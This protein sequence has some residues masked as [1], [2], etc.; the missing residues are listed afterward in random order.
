MVFLSPRETQRRIP[1]ARRVGSAGRSGAERSPQQQATSGKRA[2]S[3]L[4]I[5]KVAGVRRRRCGASFDRPPIGIETHPPDSNRRPAAQKIPSRSSSRG[6]GLESDLVAEAFESTNTTTN[7]PLSVASI[8][9]GRAEFLVSGSSSDEG[10]G[11]DQDFVPHGYHP[12]CQASS[13]FTGR[14]RLSYII[15]IRRGWA[16]QAHEH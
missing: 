1:R 10:A 7:G 6:H 13:T 2:L 16:A 15:L 5:A 8:E 14:R 12:P 9:I 3:D 11:N 4:A